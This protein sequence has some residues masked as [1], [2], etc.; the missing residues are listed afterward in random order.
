[1]SEEVVYNVQDRSMMKPA[2]DWVFDMLQKGLAGGP[3]K[4]TIGRPGRS[5]DQN[6]KQWAML[7]DI[8]KHI[9]EWHGHK[10]T[11]EDYKDLLSAA[12]KQQAL[13]PGVDGGFV[14]LGVRTSKL[15]KPDF[16]GLIELYYAFGT[17][18]Q[19]PWSEPAL[20]AY[21]EY[22]EYKETRE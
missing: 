16:S 9:P 15:N 18:H 12:W 4:I 22:R 8:C 17:Q 19:V 1:M 7:T 2:I 10:M 6:S 11:P 3:A 13:V 21:E 20:Q 14:A 5:N